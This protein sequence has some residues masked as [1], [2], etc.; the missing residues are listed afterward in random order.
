[1]T[2]PRNAGTRSL[3]RRVMLAS[4]MTMFL[5]LSGLAVFVRLNV[6]MR[7]ELAAATDAFSEEQAIADEMLR[8]V[9]R[10]LVAGSFFARRQHAAS[11]AEFRTAGD[12][13]YE[14]IRLYL[15][16]V[17]SPG[18]RLQLEAVK[19][20]QERLEVAATEAFGLFGRGHEAA[21]VQAADRMVAHGLSLQTAL[22]KFLDLRKRDLVSLQERQASTFRYLYAGAGGFALLLLLAALYLAHLLNRR[23][24]T[25]LA[26]LIDATARIGTGDLQARLNTSH[27]DEF[28]TVADS[29]NRMTERLADAKLDLEDRNTRLLAALESLR[30][31]QQEIIQ[32]EKLSAMGRM[33]AGLAHELNNPLASVLGHAELLG[34]HLDGPERLDRAA[35]RRECL[36]PLLGEAIRARALVRDFLQLARHPDEGV[37]SVRLQDALHVVVRLRAYTFEQAGL[38]VEVGDS[39]EAWVRAQP[40]RLEQALLNIANNALDAMTDRPGG[41]LA[42]SLQVGPESTDITFDDDGP[43]FENLE[44]ALEPFFTTKPVG[45][46]TGLGLALVRQFMEE[47][48]GSVQVENRPGGGAR[49]VLSLRNAEPERVTSAC[50]PSL[51]ALQGVSDISKARI[52]IVEDEEPLRVLQRRFLARLGAEVVAVASVEEAQRVVRETEFDLIVSD[53]RLPGGQNGIDLYRWVA[54]ERPRLRERFLFV[55][56][57]VADP[58][59]AKLIEH[60]ADCVLHKPFL[61]KEYLER[62][63]TLLALSTERAPAGTHGRATLDREAGSAVP[64]VA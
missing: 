51:E 34:A 28:V 50:E 1:M 48:G 6:G 7:N 63:T 40:Q 60:R 27:D 11:M 23:I 13:A 45:E 52:L 61:R 8:A 14:Q 62:V 37:R 19:E 15:F 38:R 44:R 20:Q 26:E 55:T 42:I 18:Q 59:L 53:V 21:A 32:A 2:R 30:A 58:E 29:F 54:V 24:G 36:Q 64:R 9:T 33:M 16:R 43:G 22:N 57:D 39:A 5:I 3:R 17:L 49:V 25:P 46:G 31:M 47:F 12:L 4:A 10:Q 35:I 56:G 41:R